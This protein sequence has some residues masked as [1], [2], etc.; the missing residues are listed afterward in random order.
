MR[1][2]V[3]GLEAGHA[4]PADA[5]AL[6]DS[7]SDRLTD[8]LGKDG[9]AGLREESAKEVDAAGR[10]GTTLTLVQAWARVS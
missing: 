8:I 9:L 1:T 5:A 4:G 3:L 10:R 2:H 7:L 6:A